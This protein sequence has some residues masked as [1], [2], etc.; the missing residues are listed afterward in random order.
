[1]DLA[2]L[3]AK[4]AAF[5]ADGRLRMSVEMLIGSGRA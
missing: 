5:E 1:M 4:L 3:R 2:E